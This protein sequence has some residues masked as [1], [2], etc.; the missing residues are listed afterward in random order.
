MK[1][2]LEDLRTAEAHHCCIFVAAS[3]P[4]FTGRPLR[5]LLKARA[6]TEVVLECRPQ[7]YPQ[8]VTL[9][10]KGNEILHRT[11][12]WFI[13]LSINTFAHLCV[14]S[15]RE[16]YT[17]ICKHN[18]K[19]HSISPITV[20]WFLYF[21][22]LCFLTLTVSLLTQDKNNGPLMISCLL[23]CLHMFFCTAQVTRCFMLI[24]STCSS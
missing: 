16:G 14:C 19:E 24:Q 18:S 6:G 5:S 1:Q 23:G 4:D 9:W 22:C 15:W 17:R 20:N 3:P 2:V 7:A 10:K 11:E 8:A 12:R 21:V 13:L